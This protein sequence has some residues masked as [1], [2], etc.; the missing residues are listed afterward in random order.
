MVLVLAVVCNTGI[1]WTFLS[2]GFSWLDLSSFA[3]LSILQKQIHPSC[4][5]INLATVITIP[6]SAF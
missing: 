1:K 5:A 4:T 3:L 2:V 6:F